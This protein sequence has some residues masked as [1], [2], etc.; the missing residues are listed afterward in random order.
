MDNILET[1]HCTWGR[2]EIYIIY[3]LGKKRID[4]LYMEL[5]SY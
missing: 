5:V 1:M 4:T 3:Y 2:K